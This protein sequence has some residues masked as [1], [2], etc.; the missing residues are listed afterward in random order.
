MSVEIDI[1]LELLGFAT[2]YVHENLEYIKN[3][4]IEQKRVICRYPEDVRDD[5][6]RSVADLIFS[7]NE[8]KGEGH[9]EDIAERAVDAQ[10]SSF[11]ALCAGLEQEVQEYDAEL[12]DE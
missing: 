6:I 10:V 1:E 12:D 3:L 7:H 4:S 5:T 11:Y 8:I 9:A 2:K